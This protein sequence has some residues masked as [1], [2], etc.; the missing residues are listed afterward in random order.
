MTTTIT[1]RLTRPCTI[2]Y[3]SP[4]PVDAHNN[5]TDVWTEVETHCVSAAASPSRGR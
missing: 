2:R 4:G 3:Q 1:R 5:P